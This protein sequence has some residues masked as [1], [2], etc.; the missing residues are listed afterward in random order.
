MKSHGAML[1]LMAAS[2]MAAVAAISP[3]GRA[4]DRDAD[5]PKPPRKLSTDRA[6][7]SYDICYKRVG[8]F[9]D[10]KERD[11][12]NSY[13]MDEGWID[14]RLRNGKRRFIVKD[15]A[16]VLERLYGVVEPY[17]KSQAAPPV[18]APVRDP[19]VA[20]AVQEAAAAKQARK[21]AKRAAIAERNAAR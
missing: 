13:D 15:G 20:S 17:F 8:V 2:T 9:F 18:Q 7:V 1:G 16:Y 6:D 14:R 21:A 3:A 11:D 10:G 4:P 5:E 19:A 12:V